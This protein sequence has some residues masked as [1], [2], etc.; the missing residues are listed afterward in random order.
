MNTTITLNHSVLANVKSNKTGVVLNCLINLLSFLNKIRKTDNFYGER[1][2]I[3]RMIASFDTLDHKDR[4][5]SNYLSY[6][7]AI[8][9]ESIVWDCSNDSLAVWKMA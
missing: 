8:Q 6:L 3:A 1:A 7:E 2:R 9:T 4:G 5:Y